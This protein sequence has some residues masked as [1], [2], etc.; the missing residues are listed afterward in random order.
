MQNKLCVKCLSCFPASRPMTSF[1]THFNLLGRVLNSNEEA[2]GCSV[3]SLLEIKWCTWI[4][5]ALFHRLHG[6]E[7]KPGIGY[8]RKGLSAVGWGGAASPT[9]SNVQPAAWQNSSQRMET[10][11]HTSGP[12]SALHRLKA[13]WD[14]WTTKDSWLFLNK[15]LWQEVVFPK[16]KFLATK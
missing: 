14:T 2:Y 15:L 6:R 4:N 10:G 7:E 8:N 9:L 5:C 11:P 1:Q 12:G 3:N 16:T 13:L